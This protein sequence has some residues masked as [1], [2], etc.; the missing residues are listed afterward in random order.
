MSF[1]YAKRSELCFSPIYGLS[2][3]GA[4]PFEALFLAVYTVKIRGRS[5]CRLIY[6]LR[7]ILYFR[8][9]SVSCVELVSNY[10]FFC[11]IKRLLMI[12]GIAGWKYHFSAVSKFGRKEEEQ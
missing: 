1:F 6:I 7:P 5:K 10:D 4:E 11:V 9:F 12:L 8:A 3:F 2:G